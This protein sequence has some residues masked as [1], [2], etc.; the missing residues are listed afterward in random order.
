[1]VCEEFYHVNC[2]HISDQLY[3][4]MEPEKKA[5][6]KCGECLNKVVPRTE[7][8]KTPQQYYTPTTISPTSGASTPIDTIT[9]RQKFIINVST[10]NSFGSLPTDMEE[11]DDEVAQSQDLNRSCPNN[12][13]KGHLYVEELEKKLRALRKEYESAEE[14]IEI[15]LSENSTLKKKVDTYKK[16]IDHMTTICTSTR[17]P[18][19]QDSVRRSARKQSHKMRQSLATP[20]LNYSFSETLK[21]TGECTPKPAPKEDKKNIVK[22]QLEITSPR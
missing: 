15:L 11:S 18:V 20:K 7:L 10:D 3:D 2:T 13:I 5:A 1:M 14:Q 21:Q 8:P 12:T 6:W 16:K 4:I 19:V 17:S 9:L 22:Q